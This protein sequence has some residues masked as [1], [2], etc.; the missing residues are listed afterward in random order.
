MDIKKIKFLAK[1][2][3]NALPFGR[4]GIVTPKEYAHAL[5]IADELT[6]DY[7]DSY[8]ILLDVLWPPIQRY[9]GTAPEFT[10]FNE[11]F[12]RSEAE[13][14]KRQVELIKSRLNQPEIDV[15]I[16]GL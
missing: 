4:E 13:D 2:L 3:Q 8:A 7:K 9:E 5:A 16:D 6:D 14:K 10:E 12:A 11:R 1:E 15:D